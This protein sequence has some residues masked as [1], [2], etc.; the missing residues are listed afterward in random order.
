MGPVTAMSDN[1]FPANFRSCPSSAALHHKAS[2][3]YYL[4]CGVMLPIML[5]VGVNIMCQMS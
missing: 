4:S 3:F 5:L 1:F 2:Y